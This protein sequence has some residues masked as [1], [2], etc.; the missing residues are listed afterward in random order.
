MTERIIVGIDSSDNSRAAAAVAAELARAL[1]A[2]VIAVHALGLLERF[3]GEG[4]AVPAQGQRSR[5][6]ERFENDWC[7]PL[8]GLDVDKRLV[9]GSP[10]P[11]LLG[12]ADQAGDLIVLGR[13]G[14]GGVAGLSLGSTSAQVA[15][16]APVP[17]VV[18]PLP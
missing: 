17:V 15:E 2:T 5:I 4:A 7:Q 18:V 13:R 16:R 8:D 3:R 1:G 9:D 6:A 14:E 11:V 12:V 10:V